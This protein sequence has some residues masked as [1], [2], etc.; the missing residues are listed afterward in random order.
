MLH[1][2]TDTLFSISDFACETINDIIQIRTDYMIMVVF[3]I[4]LLAFLQVLFFKVFFFLLWLLLY[5]YWLFIFE[6]SSEKTVTD[7]SLEKEKRNV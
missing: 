2:C 5:F 7:I 1:F 4:I 6:K 3:G